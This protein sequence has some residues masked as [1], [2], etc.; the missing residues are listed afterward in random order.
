MAFVDALD[1]RTAIFELVPDARSDVWPRYVSLAE[2]ML[3]RTLRHPRMIKS[4]TVTLLSNEAVLPSDYI[5]MIEVYRSGQSYGEVHIDEFDDSYVG[6]CYAIADN[7]IHLTGEGDQSIRYYAK[8]PTLADSLTATNWLLDEGPDVYL[9]SVAAE[10]LKRKPDEWAAT[11]RARETA[12][13][14]LN[15]AGNRLQYGNSVV[16]VKGNTP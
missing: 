14:Q 16:R 8:V 13:T 3:N 4:V 11:M 6:Y 12:L 5:E 15:S 7:K 10:A 1:L 9:Y 2:T